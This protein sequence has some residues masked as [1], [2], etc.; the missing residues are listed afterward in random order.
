MLH[1]IYLKKEGGWY[2][3][4]HGLKKNRRTNEGEE[5]LRERRRFKEKRKQE[6]PLYKGIIEEGTG[7]ERGGRLKEKEFRKS[8]KG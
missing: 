4:E 7:T 6:K 5:G 2:G 1:K 3:E 8:R